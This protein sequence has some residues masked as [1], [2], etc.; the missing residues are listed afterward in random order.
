MGSRPSCC[1]LQVAV[2]TGEAPAL[3]PLLLRLYSAATRCCCS[4]SVR[5]F[6]CMGMMSWVAMCRIS[7]TGCCT[8][9]LQ[10]SVLANTAP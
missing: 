2:L 10:R 3:L 6:K 7:N 5:D 8:P 9:K 1:F 4:A